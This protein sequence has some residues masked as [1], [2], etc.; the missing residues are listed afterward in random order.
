[1]LR[2]AVRRAQ[3]TLHYMRWSRR[4]ERFGW[5]STLGRPH[6][7]AGL[8][9]VRIGR[10]VELGRFWRLEAIGEFHGHR[11]DGRIDIGDGVAAEIGLHVAAACEV[12]IGPEVLIASWVFIS[13]HSHGL[14]GELPPRR[15]PLEDPQP[16]RIGAGSW[17][18]ERCVILPGVKLGE[19]CVVGAGAVVTRGFP[20]GSVIAGVPARLV[21]QLD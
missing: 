3:L 8:R 2:R 21:R 11:H 1:V 15:A 6:K 17:L 20:A 9:R 5:G 10:N 16:V 19:R 7:P 13:D 18:G 12:V 4:F 14:G